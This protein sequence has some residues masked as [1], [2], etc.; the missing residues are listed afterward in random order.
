M[1]SENNLVRDF[2]Q[3]LSS[4]TLSKRDIINTEKQFPNNYIILYYIGMYYDGKH[5]IPSATKYF[6]RCISIFQIFMY[7]LFQLANYYKNP[8]E[9]LNEYEPLLVNLLNKPTYNPVTGKIEY[10]FIDQLHIAEL[11]SCSRVS[12]L[13]A[14]ST[15]KRYTEDLEKI[16]MRFE[17]TDPLRNSAGDDEGQEFEDKITRGY[18][19]LCI[20]LSISYLEYGNQPEKAMRVLIKTFKYK[21]IQTS[22]EIQILKRFKILMN[23]VLKRPCLPKTVEDMFNKEEVIEFKNFVPL[24]PPPFISLLSKKKI[25]LGYLSGDFNKSATGLFLTPLLKH[26]D[27]SRFNVFCYYTRKE[28][29]LFTS[30]FKSYN[31]NWYDISNMSDDEA[32]PLIKSH[33]LDILIDLDVFSVDSRIE[34]SNRKP[35]RILINY[36]GY[37]NTANLISYDYRIVD[38]LT[39]PN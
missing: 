6:K 24:P 7:P 39:D 3:K 1:S 17:S 11:L 8:T 33:N 21:D 16:L 10:R 5:D 18:K 36:I 28:S 2:Y 9:F 19:N 37:P 4:G 29:D 34:L 31:T 35:A 12:G 22:L 30:L 14:L 32:Y 13:G 25:N 23:Y 15:E 20:A 26:Y 38:S 27:K